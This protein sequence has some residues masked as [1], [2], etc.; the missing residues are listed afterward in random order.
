MEPPNKKAKLDPGSGPEVA[1]A[2]SRGS[3]KSS[4][5]TAKKM[6]KSKKTVKWDSNSSESEHLCGK[7]RSQPMKE[8]VK[9][10]QCQHADKWA[11]DLPSLQSYRQQ[12]GIIPD[13][14]P[15][16]EFKDHSDYI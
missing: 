16:N 2:V 4:K 1:D 14:P 7:L 9:K 13:N 6:P 8:E 10:H 11:S 5:K 12:K 15:P 3:K